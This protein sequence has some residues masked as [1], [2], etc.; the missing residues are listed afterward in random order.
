LKKS[1]LDLGM[2]ALQ[3][4]FGAL[5]TLAEMRGLGL[6]FR[7]KHLNPQLPRI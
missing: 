3:P 5:G 6:V 7:H 4:G 2:D 1:L